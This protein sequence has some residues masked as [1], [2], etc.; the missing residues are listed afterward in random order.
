[1]QAA[2]PN[3]FSS[4]DAV[5]SYVPPV[6]APQP[7]VQSTPVA[8]QTSNKS[9]ALEDQ[10][11]FF[12]LGVMDGSEAEKEKFLDQ[13]QEVI[14]EDF[15]EYDVKLLITSDEM[16]EFEK[17][18]ANYNPKNLEQQEKIV[19]FLEKLIPDL[20]EIM[21]EK[22]LELKADMVRERVA[23]LREYFAGRSEKLEG[24]DKAESHM[25]EDRWRSAAEVLNSL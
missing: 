2:S 8:E 9:E 10:N 14:W 21:M 20:E 17:V 25:A 12:L 5:N 15:L 4:S 6:N 23:G 1:M 7:V 11:I 24:L 3:S 13:L 22:A 19:V 18:R 16:V